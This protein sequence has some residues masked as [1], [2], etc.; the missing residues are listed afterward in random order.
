MNK[1]QDL[2]VLRKTDL[3]VE[4][5]KRHPAFANLPENQIQEII[6]TIKTIT[7]IAFNFNDISNKPLEKSLKVAKL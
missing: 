6:I 5:V 4:E 1:F 7:E 3:T 2:D